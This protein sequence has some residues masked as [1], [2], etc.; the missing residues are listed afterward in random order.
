MANKRHD[1]AP[2]RPASGAWQGAGAG[3][4]RLNIRVSTP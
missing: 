1:T 3:K 2:P 4:T